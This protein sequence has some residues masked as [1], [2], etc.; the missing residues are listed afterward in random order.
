MRKSRYTQKRM[1][2]HRQGWQTCLLA[3]ER[4]SKRSSW[5]DV[6]DENARN[7][8][9]LSELRVPD[10]RLPINEIGGAAGALAEMISSEERQRGGQ[11]PKGAH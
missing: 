3:F 2:I 1:S 8:T 9:A 5:Q 11:S 4:L 10:A 6:P 7:A